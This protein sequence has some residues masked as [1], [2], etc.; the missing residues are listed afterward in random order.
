MPPRNVDVLIKDPY[1]TEK[2]DFILD[3]SSQQ[4][5]IAPIVTESTHGSKLPKQQIVWRNVFL[6]GLL[7]LSS[8]YGCYCLIG[9]HVLT[10][11]WTCVI[12]TFSALG[13]TGG[14][15]RLWAHKTYKA[16]TALKI[17]LALCQ[18][19]AFQND[20]ID[21]VRD[22][23]VHHRHSETDADPHNA[24]RGFFFAHIGW[25]LVRKHPEVKAKGQLIY[26]DD[27]LNDPVCIWQRRLYIP[28]VIV[29]CFIFPAIVPYILWEED[30]STSFFTCSLLRYCL[31][32]NATWL[33]NSAAHMWGNRP[34]N[35]N[36]NPVEN[37][38]VTFSA[39]GEGFH[40][41]HHQFPHDYSASEFG[42][43]L[44]PT[45]FFI[46]CMQKIGQASHLKKVPLDL[47]KRRMVKTGDGTQGFG[48]RPKPNGS[49]IK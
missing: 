34:Y 2:D 38:F 14:A 24:R 27:V 39:I 15:H 13:I 16:K 43:K 33:V 26:I 23:R 46:D 44:N 45:T 11:L 19:M 28:S 31:A 37:F 41:Y 49:Q 30:L 40:N 17:F 21:W 6:M 42:W 12:Y 32:L 35:V 47:V 20:I 1:C 18:S 10:W 29:M 48:L 22:H 7:H 3:S 4:D 8:V 36:I 25:L 5:S 9:A